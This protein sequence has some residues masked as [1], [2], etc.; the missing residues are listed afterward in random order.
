MSAPLRCD[1]FEWSWLP[2]ADGAA[3]AIIDPPYGDII[4]VKWDR[5]SDHY[6]SSN[7]TRLF[8]HLSQRMLP[9]SH[10]FLW[11]GFGVPGN[12]TLFRSIL[13]IEDDT[14]WKMA[15][16]NTWKKKRA[17]GTPWRCLCTREECPRFVLGDIKKPRVFNIQYRDELRGY[18]GFNPKHPAKD[19]RKRM[20]MI[21][22]HASDMG[23][24]PHPQHKPAPLVDTQI[25]M[26]TN[27]G[28]LVLDLFTGS[29]EV[30]KRCAALGR[31]VV[32]VGLP[33]EECS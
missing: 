25:L 30:A 3:L 9:G 6:L 23:K 24:K 29:G 17:Y 15:A 19:E 14:D 5:M 21:W 12:R 16:F 13:G 28:D 33:D 8:W 27:P 18:A 22:D 4:G 10:A 26:C 1:V 31:E 11:G 20:T 2:R 7:L 32:S